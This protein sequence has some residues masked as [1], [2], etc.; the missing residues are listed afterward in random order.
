MEN[1]KT[2]DIEN[3]VKICKRDLAQLGLSPGNIVSVTFNHRAKTLFGRCKKDR[4]GNFHIEV[5]TYLNRLRSEDDIC[6]TV[7]HEV[8]H[9]LPK[10]GNHGPHFQEVARLVNIKLGY[11]IATTSKLSTD[12]KEAIPFKYVVKCGLCG[13]EMKRYHRKPQLTPNHYHGACGKDSMGK[14]Q[15]FRYVYEG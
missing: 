4:S 14:L 11:R 3:M 13:Q 1:M 10:C 9:T 2:R 8:I 15:L 7:M 5:M 12:E 6:Q